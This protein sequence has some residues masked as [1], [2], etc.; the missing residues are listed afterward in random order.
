[1]PFA[2]LSTIGPSTM[3]RPRKVATE[4]EAGTQTRNH[5]TAFAIVL[6]DTPNSTAIERSLRPAARNAA[7]GPARR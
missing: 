3:D 5:R 7:A 2:V 1:M 4:T 6:S